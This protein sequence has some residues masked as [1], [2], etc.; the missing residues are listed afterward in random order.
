ML[1]SLASSPAWTSSPASEATC[2]NHCFHVFIK[3]TFVALLFGAIAKML[4]GHNGL[5][6]QSSLRVCVRPCVRR[7]YQITCNPLTHAFNTKGVTHT[8]LERCMDT[9]INT[10]H[11]IHTWHVN[12]RCRHRSMTCTNI[13]WTIGGQSHR[14]STKYRPLAVDNRWTIGGQSVDNRWAINGQSVDNRW[15]VG[16]QSVDN[17]VMCHT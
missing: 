14:L 15:T 8:Q 12:K 13:M 17:C 5:V 16:G 11:R 6:S 3:F 1:S 10:T 9:Y 7:V 4:Y 2:S